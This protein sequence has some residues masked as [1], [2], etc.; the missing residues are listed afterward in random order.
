MEIRGEIDANTARAYRLPVDHGVVVVPQPGSP[1]ER[2]GMRA[3][4]IIVAVDGTRVATIGDLR[5][6]LFRKRPGDA[7]RVE[8]V[9]DGRRLTLTVTLTELRSERPGG[10][11]A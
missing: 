6:E 7:V 5:R 10:V 2:A 9:R 8:V 4:D 1:A 11:R 3:Q